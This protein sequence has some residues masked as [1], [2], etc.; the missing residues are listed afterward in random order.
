MRG[1]RGLRVLRLAPFLA[2]FGAGVREADGLR[3]GDYDLCGGAWLKRACATSETPYP[4][5]S[6]AR[7]LM[8]IDPKPRAVASFACFSAPAEV[9][10]VAN[11]A[12]HRE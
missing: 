10:S 12:S 3:F 9:G 11:T 8:C 4:F 5:S 1:D 2:V 7:P 6:T